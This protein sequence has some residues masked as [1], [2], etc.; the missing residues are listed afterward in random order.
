MLHKCDAKHWGYVIR[1]LQKMV[2]FKKIKY[3]YMLMGTQKFWFEQGVKFCA[4]FLSLWIKPIID[5]FKKKSF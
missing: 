3:L 2:F 4:A 1:N 5:V